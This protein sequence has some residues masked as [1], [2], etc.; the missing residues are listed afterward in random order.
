VQI[1][2]NEYSLQDAT[3]SEDASRILRGQIAKNFPFLRR[4]AIGILNQEN[5]QKRSLRKNL[6]WFP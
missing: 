4:M 3:F 1:H 2:I 5:S 6:A